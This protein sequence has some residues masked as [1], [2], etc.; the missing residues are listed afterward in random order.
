MIFS[1]E[2]GFPSF[3][4]FLYIHEGP[5]YGALFDGGGGPAV[6][7]AAPDKKFPCLTEAALGKMV[8]CTVH[9]AKKAPNFEQKSTVSLLCLHS[10]PSLEENPLKETKKPTG[11]KSATPQIQYLS[12]HFEKDFKGNRENYGKP[13]TPSPEGRF[14]LPFPPKTNRRPLLPRDNRTGLRARLRF[15]KK[16]KQSL[17]PFFASGGACIEYRR[18]GGARSRKKK[19]SPPVLV[20][21]VSKRNGEVGDLGSIVL[22]P[23]RLSRGRR[24]PRPNAAEKG[25]LAFLSPLLAG[26]PAA[27]KG[28]R[29]R[30]SPSF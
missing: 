14:P 29:E 7:G 20:L 28:E 3:P 13:L 17:L 16:K 9:T 22:R 10:G 5:F 25:L 18:E 8:V 11:D 2:L 6:T 24:R 21:G 23:P 26:Q 30:E 4:P 15:R 19:P 12:G 1:V 27:A